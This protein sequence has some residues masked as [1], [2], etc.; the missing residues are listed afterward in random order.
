MESW[1]RDISW[2]TMLIN[3]VDINTSDV[4]Q[5]ICFQLIILNGANRWVYVWVVKKNTENYE[6]MIKVCP[7]MSQ[8]GGKSTSITSTTYVFTV[9]SPFLYSIQSA[10][11][12]ALKLHL[13]VFRLIN[14][15]VFF[16]PRYVVRCKHAYNFYRYMISLL[17]F[18]FFFKQ[19]WLWSRLWWFIHSCIHSLSYSH[20]VAGSSHFVWL[21]IIGQ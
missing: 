5:F 20:Q 15:R 17:L 2:A 10:D 9:I 18:V 3:G 13:H 12:Q 19:R 14:E 8:R 16:P 1:A 7:S 4:L 6:E 11:R 21:V